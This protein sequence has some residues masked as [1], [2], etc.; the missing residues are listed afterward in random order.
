M[1]EPRTF[2]EYLESRQKAGARYG[3]LHMMEDTRIFLKQNYG[4]KIFL[5]P[6][7][8]FAV[9]SLIRYFTTASWFEVDGQAL[10]R[11]GQYVVSGY[12]WSEILIQ[13]LNMA[14]GTIFLVDVF[15]RIYT[16]FGENPKFVMADGFKAI[17]RILLF[18]LI[19]TIVML[20]ITF[21]FALFPIYILG[22]LL[23]IPVVCILIVTGNTIVQDGKRPF[24][25][26]IGH[27]ISLTFK[28][29]GII[30]R[31]ILVSIVIFLVMLVVLNLALLLPS[32]GTGQ[33]IILLVGQ[34]LTTLISFLSGTFLAI[35]YCY[36][37]DYRPSYAL[38][39]SL[40]SVEAIP[41]AFDMEEST[42]EKEDWEPED[43]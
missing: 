20:P 6:L 34:Y 27:G 36:Y 37:D 16:P 41:R 22:Y 7:I 31:L 14:A 28:K 39:R 30:G 1:T 32:G 9:T 11:E 43:E 17:V 4:W 25:E 40:K 2:D 23:F 8:L 13:F 38:E 3:T 10:W 29:P 5:F 35:A 21:I 33:K 42:T 18:T 19:F 24:F 12:S 15:K 26:S